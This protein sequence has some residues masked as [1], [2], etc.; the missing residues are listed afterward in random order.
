LFYSSDEIVAAIHTSGRR[1]TRQR[2][3]IIEY[4]AG[5]HDHPSA[6]QIFAALRAGET[7][8]SLATVYNTLTAL[9]ELG[10]IKEIEFEADNNRYDTNVSPH[11]NLVCSVCG[12][13]AD[14]DRTPP[15]SAD[16]IQ[17]VFGF[18]TTDI[19]MEYH[20]ICESCRSEDNDQ[21]SENP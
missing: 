12:S 15:V 9:V 21:R 16:E 6:R 2:R 10:F 14:I 13:I 8:M 5:R 1:L 7:P 18:E 11:I 17:A 3:V 20:G 19:R 4:L